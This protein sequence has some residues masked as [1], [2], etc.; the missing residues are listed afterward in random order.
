MCVTNLFLNRLSED[1]A[2]SS[3]SQT[4][5]RGILWPSVFSLVPLV[6]VAAVVLCAGSL[7]QAGADAKTSST[8]SP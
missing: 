8:A 4:T 6:S 2:I 5:V 3:C 7:L 1:S